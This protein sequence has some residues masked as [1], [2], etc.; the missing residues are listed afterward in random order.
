MITANG[1]VQTIEEAQIHVHD[2]ELFVTEKILDDPHAV[3]SSGKLCEEHG[4]T[5]E[6]A[7]DQKP[8]LTKNGQQ[9]VQYR[10]CRSYCCPKIDFKHARNV[11]LCIVPAGLIEHLS[12]SR[13][14]TK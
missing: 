3:L 13:K 14:S 12:E 7:S 1:E 6:W 8:Y 10:K 5:Y 9:S 2:R 4:Y 11:V